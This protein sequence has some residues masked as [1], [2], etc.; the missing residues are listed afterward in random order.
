MV[1][2]AKRGN[3]VCPLHELQ[4]S[5]PPVEQDRQDDADDELKPAGNRGDPAPSCATRHKV[6]R[7]YTGKRK[8]CEN[9]EHCSAPPYRTNVATTATRRTPSPQAKAM[10]R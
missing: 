5:I 10:S 8:K 2:R 3:P 4:G 6:E 7:Q 1:A 9:R